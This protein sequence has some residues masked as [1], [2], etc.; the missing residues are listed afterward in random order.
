MKLKLTIILFICLSVDIVR[1][2]EVTVTAAFDSARIYLGDQIN[3]TVTV[4]K[5]I[6]YL[7]A[8][9]VFK[10]TLYKKIEILNGPVTDT[11]VLKD[12]RIRIRQKYL[13]TSFDSGFYQVPPVYAELRTGNSIKRF[14]SDYS[15]LEVMRVK[16]TP[17]D[18]TSKIFD[19]IGPYHAPLTIG[20]V[21]PWILLLAAISVA[22]WYIIRLVGRIKRRKEGTEQIVIPDPAHIIAFR[23]LEKLKEEK[24][25]QE[26]QIKLYYTRLSEIIRQ[27]LENRFRISSLELTTV[28][29]LDELKRSGFREDESFRKLR[30]ILTGADLVKFAKYFPE[31][32]ENELHFEY[33]WDFVSTTRY[34]EQVTEE[35]PGDKSGKEVM[36]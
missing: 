15:Q 32:S 10:D 14:Y 12:G 4:D 33:A 22:V 6:S 19:I 20:E 24:L 8:I 34:E 9:P 35:K 1:A 31:P 27:Y 18:S 7:L 28:E 2:Q 26:G 23:A 13:I 29:T 25:W 11:S 17:P 36:L 16:I 3:Y 30:T 21:M 5:P